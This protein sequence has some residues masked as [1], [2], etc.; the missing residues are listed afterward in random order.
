MFQ[1]IPYRVGITDEE[2]VYYENSTGANKKGDLKTLAKAKKITPLLRGA[3]QSR[4]PEEAIKFFDLG[5][6]TK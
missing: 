2:G 4:T 5:A 6:A 3:E 1:E